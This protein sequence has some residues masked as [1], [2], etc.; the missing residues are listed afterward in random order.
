M[1]SHIYFVLGFISLIMFFSYHYHVEKLIDDFIKKDKDDD[2]N[3]NDDLKEPEDLKRWLYTMR[4]GGNE[5]AYAVS[6]YFELVVKNVGSNK[7]ADRAFLSLAILVVCLVI[8][9]LLLLWDCQFI[10]CRQ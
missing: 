9:C 7:Y 3:L 2:L 6:K 10:Y 8:I 5:K 1:L 4:N